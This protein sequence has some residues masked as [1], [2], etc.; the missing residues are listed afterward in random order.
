FDASAFVKLLVDEDGSDLA[1]AL[2]DVCDTAV[3]SRLAYPEVRAALAAA[4]RD[5]RLDADAQREAEAA[6]E[7]YWAATR[8][9]EL[10]DA[11][12]VHAGRLAG[13]LALR[14][15][16]AVHLASALAVGA[17]ELL[18]AAWDQGLRSGA[19]MVGIQVVPAADQGEEAVA[20]RPEAT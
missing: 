4:G 8:P 20:E 12:T 17:D 3:S 14:G 16:D 15:A 7:G 18:F 13:E 6:W 10:T 9:V 5:H 11:V 19:R 2:W 1:A